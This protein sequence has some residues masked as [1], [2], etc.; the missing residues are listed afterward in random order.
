MSVKEICKSQQMYTLLSA[1]DLVE[2]MWIDIILAN[3]THI[4]EKNFKN[5]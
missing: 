2:I 4:K 5:Q 3:D 1:L